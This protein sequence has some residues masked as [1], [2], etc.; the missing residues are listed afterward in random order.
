MKRIFLC[1]VIGT[2]FLLTSCGNFLD[3]NDDPNNPSSVGYESTFPA[4][5]GSTAYVVGGRYVVLGSIWSQH[6]T[7][8]VAANQYNKIDAYGID[9]SDFNRE[10]N[11]LYAGAGQDYIDVIRKTREVGD[12]NTHLMAV[13]MKV[14]T[15]Q[16][17]A[18]LYDQIPYS[19]AFGGAGSLQPKWDDGKDVYDALIAELDDALAKD[20]TAGTNT[21]IGRNDLV[22]G[23]DISK[24]KQFI[25]TLKLKIYLRQY[26][27]RPDVASAGISSLFL[28][29]NFLT[30]HACLA[31]FANE[32]GKF[33]PL[34]GT[35]IHSSGLGDPNLRAS[36]TLYTY[37]KDNEDLRLYRIYRKENGETAYYALLQGDRLNDT[38]RNKLSR[39]IWNPVQP[40]YF[41]SMAEINF[42][43]AEALVRYPSL[44]GDAQS[45]YENGVKASFAMFMADVQP[46]DPTDPAGNDAATLLAGDYA[47]PAGGT[48]AQKIEAIITQKWVAQAKFNPIESFL[49]FNRTGY[50]TFFTYSKTSAIGDR[51]PRRLLFP[52]DET[53]RNKNTPKQVAIDVPVW[54]VK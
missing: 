12:W 19:D 34:Y 3:I 48:E 35:D 53:S 14:Y 13:A 1:L 11:E 17:V 38:Y 32:A 7:Q 5:V 54:W 28:S 15:F 29:P 18:D 30:T 37:L 10:F 47:Y 22:F 49:D 4:A 42:L 44:T 33:N 39:G 36:L 50:P 41:F 40:V 16:I 45:Y 8:N 43:I 9:A 31:A 26:K 27:A 52:S 6:F 51:F 25:N 23:G 24:W 20:F 21:N 2:L 46:A